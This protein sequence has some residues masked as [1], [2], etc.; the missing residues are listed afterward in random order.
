[1]WVGGQL[2]CMRGESCSALCLLL[3]AR[4]APYTCACVC[5]SVVLTSSDACHLAEH[6]AW[7]WPGAACLLL[8]L[9]LKL[10]LCAAR[11]SRGQPLF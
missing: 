2:W 6:A 8:K 7:L 11:N 5:V 1:V 10:K 4:A 3:G 9:L